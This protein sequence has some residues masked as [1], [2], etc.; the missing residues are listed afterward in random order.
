MIAAGCVAFLRAHQHALDQQ[1]EQEA[2]PA[3]KE[4]VWILG[5]A[6]HL[7]EELMRVAKEVDR[8]GAKKDAAGKSAAERKQRVR[9]LGRA[10][11]TRQQTT[12]HP[13]HEDGPDHDQLERE[14]IDRAPALGRPSR[15]FAVA[16]GVRIVSAI[17]RPPRADRGN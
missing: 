17:A 3:D 12:D 13:E 16:T 9:S 7:G 1:D 14:K 8:S 11:D 4:E 15:R 10:D 2:D 6:A 5:A